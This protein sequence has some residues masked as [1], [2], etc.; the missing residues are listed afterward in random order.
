[1]LTLREGSSRRH[2]EREGHDTWMTFDPEVRKDPFRNGFRALEGLDEGR[3][4]PGVGVPSQSHQNLEVLTYVR[5]GL[6]LHEDDRGHAGVIRSGEF[7]YMSAGSGIRQRL[8]NGS[9]LDSA[10]VFESRLRSDTQGLPPDSGQMRISAGDRKGVFRLVASPEAQEGTFQIR[11]D[12]RV[13]SSLPDRGCHL[14]HA[15]KAGRHAWLQVVRGR[16]QL[17]DQVLIAGDGVA[18]LD[19]LAVS[20]TALEPSELLLFDLA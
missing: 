1:M 4:A 18:Y 7:K 11:Q 3:L 12:V 17:L 6:L 10:H 19:E 13:Y 2:I 15:L 16:I 14:I 5:D 8:F 20:I 9:Q